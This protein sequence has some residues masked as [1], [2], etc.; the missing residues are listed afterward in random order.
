[1][2]LASGSAAFAA[3]AAKAGS[4]LVALPLMAFD[5]RWVQALGALFDKVRRSRPSAAA[6]AAAK[7]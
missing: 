7:A 4:I 5:N 1:M 6:P 2:V 3:A